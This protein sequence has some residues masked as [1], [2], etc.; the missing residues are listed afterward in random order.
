MLFTNRTKGEPA[1]IPSRYATPCGGAANPRGDEHP[2][3]GGSGD[4]GVPAAMAC[5]ALERALPEPQALRRRATCQADQASA[6]AE[7]PHPSHG[8][9]GRQAATRRRSARPTAFQAAVVASSSFHSASVTAR[10]CS[11]STATASRPDVISDQVGKV[12]R[13]RQASTSSNRRARFARTRT[14][15]SPIRDSRRSSHSLACARFTIACARRTYLLSTRSRTVLT[16]SVSSRACAS[17]LDR[18]KAVSG[19]STSSANFIGPDSVPGGGVV[20]DPSVKASRWWSGVRP[21][22]AR[23]GRRL[24]AGHCSGAKPGSRA[25]NRSAASPVPEPGHRRCRP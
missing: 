9:C 12:T 8:R 25:A 7:R 24:A 14:P 1:L 23:Q 10:P 17:L 6:P 13:L 5:V 16:P 2:A 18:P 15:R 4:R 22:R 21:A 20:S 3:R 11:S 19:A